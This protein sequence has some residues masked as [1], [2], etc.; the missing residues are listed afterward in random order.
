LRVGRFQFQYGQGGK[1]F[2]DVPFVL[3]GWVDQAPEIRMH[4]QVRAQKWIYCLEQQI[5]VHGGTKLVVLC[6]SR[7]HFRTVIFC[8]HPWREDFRV[9]G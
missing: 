4:N 3:L 7:F 8:L 2:L 5:G 6:R 1:Y 9:D